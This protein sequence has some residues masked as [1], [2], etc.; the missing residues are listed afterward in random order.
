M[1]REKIPGDY[2]NC[3]RCPLGF[4]NR[5]PLGLVRRESVGGNGF[6]PDLPDR[7]TAY[8][9]HVLSRL[10]IPGSTGPLL[11]LSRPGQVNVCPQGQAYR[12]ALSGKPARENRR[13]T[14]NLRTRSSN[15]Q[16]NQMRTTSKLNISCR[17]WRSRPGS[18]GA[19]RMRRMIFSC[20]AAAG[21]ST[22]E[23]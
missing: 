20:L 2:Q 3:R 11:P 18:T 7:G 16:S 8:D 14:R 23:D 13:S 21:V 10:G 6:H 1:S 17:H 9:T 22:A 19:E 4:S 5:V 15:R 12:D